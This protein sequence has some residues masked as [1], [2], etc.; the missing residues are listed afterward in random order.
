MWQKIQREFEDI[1]GNRESYLHL[2]ILINKSLASSR[3]PALYSRKRPE[4]HVYQV[5][6]KYWWGGGAKIQYIYQL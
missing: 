4:F 6:S 5:I 2:M 3:F 1:C